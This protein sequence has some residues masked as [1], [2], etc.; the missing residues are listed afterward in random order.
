MGNTKDAEKRDEEIMIK[1]LAERDAKV[2]RDMAKRREHDN[3][4]K[5][6]ANR[7]LNDQITAKQQAKIL[8]RQNDAMY[9]EQIHQHTTLQ[10]NREK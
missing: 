9:A 7:M 3:R 8:S 5:N 6:E 4:L 1:Q 2:E 10:E